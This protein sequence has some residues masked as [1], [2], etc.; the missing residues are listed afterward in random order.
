ME[1]DPKQGLL[2][3]SKGSS[4]GNAGV[5][6]HDSSHSPRSKTLQLLFVSTVVLMV[7]I[8]LSLSIYRG[9]ILGQYGGLYFMLGI[10]LIGFVAV[11]IVLV[12]LIRSGE[13]P[14]EK[15][16]FLYFMGIC[17]MLEAVFTNILLFR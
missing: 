14:K 12:A 15:L 16:W 5:L 8:T 7:V 11:E 2:S 13:L 10:C 1:D 9:V 17:I 3:G 6:Y 4:S